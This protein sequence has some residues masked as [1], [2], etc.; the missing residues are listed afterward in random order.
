MVNVCPRDI[1]VGFV[2]TAREEQGESCSCY[3]IVDADITV[4]NENESVW[5]IITLKDERL[6]KISCCLFLSPT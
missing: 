4:Q 2:R 5:S 6:I 1:W 3:K